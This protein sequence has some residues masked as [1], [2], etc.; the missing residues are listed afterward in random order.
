[1]RARA[2]ITRAWLAVSLALAVLACGELKVADSAGGGDPP[3]GALPSPDAE[4]P[5]APGAPHPDAGSDA[6]APSIVKVPV[7]NEAITAGSLSV[8]ADESGEVA[9]AWL[10]TPSA[11]RHLH[12]ARIAGAE[13]PPR[14]AVLS[15]TPLESNASSLGQAVSVFTPAKACF[16]V[17]W[18][19]AGLLRVAAVGADAKPGAS[20]VLAT[21][22]AGPIARLSQVKTTPDGAGGALVAWSEL[23]RFSADATG[24][25]HAA[26]LGFAGCAPGAVSVDA[27]PLST[28][29]LPY[30]APPAGAPE[31]A[32]ARATGAFH[33][34]IQENGGGTILDVA[35]RARAGAGWGAASPVDDGG[36]V[37]SGGSVGIAENGTGLAVAYYRRTSDTI[38][39]L[40]VASVGPT[41]VRTGETV[42]EH[43]VL[44]GVAAATYLEAARLAI[45]GR[46]PKGP[47]LAAA[48]ARDGQTSE[49]RIYRADAS[50]PGGYR[51][52]LLD[53]NV[54]GPRGGGDAHALV[55]VTADAAGRIHV[56]WRSGTSKAITYARLPP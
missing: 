46:G 13:E 53:T 4:Q 50:A 45:V 3:D 16:G 52:E 47:V 33:A 6:K 56:A 38:G 20:S 36:T 27:D 37:T 31:L 8:I 15:D 5:D 19:Q 44:I 43:D 35:H 2:S 7:V 14:V 49:L 40:V 26:T 10:D 28:G 24:V 34:A 48:F 54:F 42:L 30:Q 11:Q 55:D 51:S 41:G 29:A 39:D 25:F 32:L 21:I 23:A 12:V 18:G 17:T 22:S 1:M 9:L